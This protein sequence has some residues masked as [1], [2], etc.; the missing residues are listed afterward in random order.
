MTANKYQYDVVQEYAGFRVDR[1]CKTLEEAKEVCDYY[2][3]NYH[4]IRRYT[5]FSD[6]DDEDEDEVYPQYDYA[7]GDE[8][9]FEESESECRS[10]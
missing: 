10:L 6:S 1:L 7:N 3:L 4:I 8:Y 9:P 2:N 5:K